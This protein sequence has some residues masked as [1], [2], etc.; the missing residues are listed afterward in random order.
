MGGQDYG[1]TQCLEKLYGRRAVRR[2]V[3]GEALSRV[4]RRGQDRARVRPRRPSS[5]GDRST[6]IAILRKSIAAGESLKAG[7]KVYGVCRW[8]RRSCCSTSAKSSLRARTQ[9]RRRAHR[10]AAHRPEAESRSTRTAIW[11]IWTRTTT[12][13]SRSTSGSPCRWR[14]TALWQRRTA[15]RVNIVIGEDED[16]P[17]LVH[18]RSADS[19]LPRADGARPPRRSID[20]ED[21]QRHRR[22]P[23]RSR[24][25]KRTPVKAVRAGAS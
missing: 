17:V 6:A 2:R 23:S 5:H 9:H 20:G 13:A 4:H 21:A 16:D 11:P 19:P 22:R 10:L 7:D 12:A 24:A 25:R 3:A 8:T 18:L 14:C 15:R 1:T